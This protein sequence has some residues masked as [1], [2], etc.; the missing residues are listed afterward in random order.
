[1]ETSGRERGICAV[2]EKG[3]ENTGVL[4]IED[5]RFMS[6]QIMYQGIMHCRRAKEAIITICFHRNTPASAS[7]R[8]SPTAN[9]THSKQ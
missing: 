3:R 1:M 4:L 7:R 8:K 5:I 9:T 2:S 6:D